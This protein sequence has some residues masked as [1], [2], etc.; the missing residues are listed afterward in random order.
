MPKDPA[1]ATRSERDD[2]ADPDA[3]GQAALLLVESL[4]HGLIENGKLSVTDALNIAT[5]AAEVK[6][7]VVDDGTESR[8]T[9]ELSLQMITRIVASLEIDRPS[10][11]RLR[12][13]MDGEGDR[14]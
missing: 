2:R 9:A 14:S 7:A 13:D 3:H 5:S 6:E 10:M 1:I 4:I 12:N 8:A 11:D